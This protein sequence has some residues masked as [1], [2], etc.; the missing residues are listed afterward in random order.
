MK[1]ST[2]YFDSNNCQFLSKLHENN[3]EGIVF[4]EYYL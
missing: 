4:D 1:Q 3:F 2:Y